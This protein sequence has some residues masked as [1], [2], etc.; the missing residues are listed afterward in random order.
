MSDDEKS[1]KKKMGISDADVFD[2]ELALLDVETIVRDFKIDR[3][4][5]LSI[6]I[7]SAIKV[8]DKATRDLRSILEGAK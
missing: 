3:D 7:R 2:V 5:E 6:I 8:L 4:D 1:L